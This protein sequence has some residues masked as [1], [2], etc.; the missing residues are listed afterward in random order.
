MARNNYGEQLI[1]LT[2]QE[3]GEGGYVVNFSTAE[4]KQRLLTFL[5]N[6]LATRFDPYSGYTHYVLQKQLK[7]DLMDKESA[8]T[9]HLTQYFVSDDG[10]DII[11][12]FIF[13]VTDDPSLRIAELDITYDNDVVVGFKIYDVVIA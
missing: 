2:T 12:R 6:N 1:N 7:I 3:D 5:Q 8:F 11:F 4:D 13:N 9:H 10:Y